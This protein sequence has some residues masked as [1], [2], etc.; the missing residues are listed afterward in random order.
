MKHGRDAFLIL[1]SDGI[2]FVMTDQEIINIVNSCSQPL[3]A[4]Q[5]VCD[6]A[7]HYGSE[8]N[9]TALIM[10]FG[11]WGKFKNH[12]SNY[13]QFYSFGRELAKSARF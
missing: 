10:P 13:S 2:N 7:L 1:T 11:A 3:T 5:Y 12:R 6:Q 4:A 8:D 9:S